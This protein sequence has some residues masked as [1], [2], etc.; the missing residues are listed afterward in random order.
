LNGQDSF[1]FVVSDD[2]TVHRTQ[3]KTGNSE[4]IMTVVTHGL[5]LGQKVVTEGLD[6]LQDGAAVKVLT[7]AEEAAINAPA[8]PQQHKW[9]RRN[10]QGGP[11]GQG[12]PANSEGQNGQGGQHNQSGQ[13]DQHT[14]GGQRQ[15]SQS[16]S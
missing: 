3:V 16:G 14:Q 6:R 2:N 4:G 1:V 15:Q 11:G 12:G 5:T 13:G 7:A 8:P 9:R 10:G